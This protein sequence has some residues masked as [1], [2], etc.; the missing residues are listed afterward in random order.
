VKPPSL[1][2][3]VHPTALDP[4]PLPSSNRVNAILHDLGIAMGGLHSP[5]Y[6]AFAWRWAR[7][8]VARRYLRVY[9]LEEADRLQRREKW[10]KRMR[11]QLYLDK[12]VVLAIREEHEWFQMRARQAHAQ[13]A[14]IEQDLWDHRLH[15]YYE[16]VRDIL[17]QWCGRAYSHV[18]RMMAVDDEGSTG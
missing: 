8:D 18:A 6:C 13:L 7:D 16:G 5:S 15:R 4:Q 2:L 12:L 17:E 14:G 1:L 3:R 9:L 10:P 11:G